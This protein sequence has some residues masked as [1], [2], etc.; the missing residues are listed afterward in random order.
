M[1]GLLEGISQSLGLE[2]NYIRNSLKLESGL[3][4]FAANLYPPCPQP[5]LAMGLPPHSDHGLLTLLIQNGISGLQIQ[6]KGK[7]VNVNAIPNSFFVNTCDHLE[8]RKHFKYKS[9]GHF[10][11]VC[12]D[13]AFGILHLCWFSRLLCRF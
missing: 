4:L 10:F 13:F 2:A 9:N 6:H 12:S 1:T 11:F 5:D 8:V 7:W 3:Q